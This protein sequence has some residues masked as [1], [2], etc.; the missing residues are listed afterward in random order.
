MQV[1]H[2][3]NDGGFL[4]SALP[5]EVVDV[6][7]LYLTDDWTV[8]CELQ[9]NTSIEIGRFPTEMAAKDAVKNFVNDLINR[10]KI[11]FLDISDENYTR[12]VAVD[13]VSSVNIGDSD[14]KYYVSV[15]TVNGYQFDFKDGLDIDEA[16]D[17]YHELL[18]KLW[19]EEQKEKHANT[20]TVDKNSWYGTTISAAK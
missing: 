8:I 19:G 18:D 17:V 4:M 3:F 6:H 20:I 13:K 12:F 7:E 1:I 11:E 16:S 14:G 5:S 2:G 10:M 15:W 9:N